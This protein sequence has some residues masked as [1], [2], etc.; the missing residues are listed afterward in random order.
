MDGLL[1]LVFKGKRI[2]DKS[3]KHEERKKTNASCS[4][5]PSMK[6]FGSIDNITH[7]ESIKTNTILGILYGPHTVSFKQY[8]RLQQLNDSIQNKKFDQWRWV[9]I[10]TKMRSYDFILNSMQD[11]VD[12]IVSVA[13]GM[14]RHS[15]LDSKKHIEKIMLGSHDKSRKKKL[16]AAQLADTRA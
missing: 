9:T 15:K 6:F 11:S 8:L 1:K 7:E 4:F 5:F 16:S 12:F 10:L 3:S 2:L 13:D 14:A